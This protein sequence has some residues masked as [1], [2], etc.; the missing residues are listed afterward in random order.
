MCPTGGQGVVHSGWPFRPKLRRP[1]WPACRRPK[2]HVQGRPVR[3]GTCRY[4]CSK[5]EVQIVLWCKTSEPCIEAMDMLHRRPGSTLPSSDNPA[6]P[7]GTVP[8]SARWPCC[9]RHRRGRTAD[10]LDARPR[11]PYSSGLW[12]PCAAGFW[13]GE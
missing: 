3:S 12:L 7:V 5:A 10:S 11:L 9:V 2:G 4:T 8:H 13:P 1:W 6:Q